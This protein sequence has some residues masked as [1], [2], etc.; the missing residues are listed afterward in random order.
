MLTEH[1]V[2]ADLSRLR[3]RSAG[4]EYTRDIPL[5]PRSLAATI[6]P[7]AALAAAATLGA[8]AVIGAGVNGS[9]ADVTRGANQSGAGSAGGALSGPGAEGATHSGTIRLVSAKITL[10]GR[11]IAYRH[12]VGEDP[13]GDGWQLAIEFGASLPAD[14]TRFDLGDGELVWV[15]DS[16][17]SSLGES[18]LIVAAG[19]HDDYIG[20]PST[21]SRAD[22]E[23]FV[24][25]SLHGH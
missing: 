19:P 23:D 3:D 25:T 16:P 17:D 13:F 8:G 10:G 21:F 2:I 15:A 4:V 18:V 9:G 12:A 24:R 1:E 11:T 6:V 20:A 5:T 22:L 14:A 7:V